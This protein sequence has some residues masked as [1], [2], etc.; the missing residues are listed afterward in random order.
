MRGPSGPYAV[1]VHDA[2]LR[3][4]A[5]GHRLRLFYPA[6]NGGAQP[7]GNA[8]WLTRSLGASPGHETL[9][10]ALRYVRAPLP[11]LLAGL[12]APVA[13]RQLHAGLDVE[14]LPAEG[15]RER[16]PLV[17]FSHGLAGSTGF[18]NITCIDLASRGYVV[19]AVEHSDGS[20]MNA[21]FG[22]ERRQV[23]FHFYGG[24]DVDGPEWD[25]RNKQ[26]TTRVDD[27]DALREE[28]RAASKPGGEPLI[29]LDRRVVSKG[30]NLVGRI[31]L[32][33]IYVAGHSYVPHLPPPP[34]DM[35]DAAFIQAPFNPFA[36]Y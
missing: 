18:Y 20:P 11:G 17:L 36:C 12:L 24:P 13:N 4:A 16:W 32:D 28:L 30:P 23:L 10:G 25:F 29:P 14:L 35:S 8:R 1:G 33:D 6:A 21:F 19:A 5:G 31:D 7:R 15:G 9:Y 2:R 34:V 22:S 27:F 26:L 3:D